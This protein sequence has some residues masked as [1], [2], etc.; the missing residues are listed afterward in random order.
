MAYFDGIQV[1]DK[2][3][4]SEYG[5]GVVKYVFPPNQVQICVDFKMDECRFD[6]SGKRN[7][8]LSCFQSLFWDEIKITPPP[9]P[10]KKEKKRVEMTAKVYPGGRFLVGNKDRSFLI[11][12]RGIDLDSAE[13]EIATATVQ[14]EWEE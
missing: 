1:G 6:Y 12:G 4:S 8:D 9:K 3:W 2:V 11:E 13:G 7:A 5:W 10:K 14:I